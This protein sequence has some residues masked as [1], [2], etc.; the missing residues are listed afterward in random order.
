MIKVN[1]IEGILN[2]F[3]LNTKPNNTYKTR[4]KPTNISEQF[5]SIFDTELSKV[6]LT[7]SDVR[8]IQESR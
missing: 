7:I 1:S 5:N 3:S 6:G 2:E 8:K 4:A